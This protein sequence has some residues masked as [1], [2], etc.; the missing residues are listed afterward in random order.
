MNIL[1]Q[2]NLKRLL[3]LKSHH[4]LHRMVQELNKQ[5]KINFNHKHQVQQNMLNGCSVRSCG[6]L[7]ILG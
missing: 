2:K 1:N 7:L 6:F 3:S 5:L 4:K